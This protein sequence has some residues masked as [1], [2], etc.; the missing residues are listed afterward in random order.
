MLRGTFMLKRF[1]S[2]LV[3]WYI[4][5][6]FVL[7]SPFVLEFA[8]HKDLRKYNQDKK[9]YSELMENVV[10]FKN[11]IYPAKIDKKEDRDFTVS[12]FNDVKINHLNEDIKILSAKF[13][14]G[15]FKVTIEIKP[16]STSCY[17]RSEISRTSKL[18]NNLTPFL[19]CNK[20]NTKYQFLAI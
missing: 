20:E 9:S 17:F 1:K 6:L 18:V 8:F 4:V 11:Q 15:Y 19:N 14:K 16:S 5:C 7:S 10:V 2:N 3:S 12:F 13:E